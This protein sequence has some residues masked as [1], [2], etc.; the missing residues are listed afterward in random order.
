[1]GRLINHSFSPELW[2]VRNELTRMNLPE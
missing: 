2:D 1:M